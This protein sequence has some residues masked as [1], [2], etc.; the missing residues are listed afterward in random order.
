MKNFKI[1]STMGVDMG[2]YQ[3]DDEAGAYL[4]FCQDAGYRTVEAAEKMAKN[5]VKIEEI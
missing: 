5:T 3:A 1:F 4:A 2:T